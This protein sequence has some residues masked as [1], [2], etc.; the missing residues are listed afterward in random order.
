MKRLWAQISSWLRRVG[1]NGALTVLPASS[2]VRS[3]GFLKVCWS[4][5]RRLP[6][7]AEVFWKHSECEFVRD[8]NLTSQ[9]NFITHDTHGEYAK[10][11]GHY[12]SEELCNNIINYFP[13]QSYNHTVPH[14]ITVWVWFPGNCGHCEYLY[15][16]PNQISIRYSE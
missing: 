2:A 15:Y 1:R 10:V 8:W 6:A 16:R 9:F 13:R 3:P 11:G 4:P 12:K 14:K 5:L 7:A